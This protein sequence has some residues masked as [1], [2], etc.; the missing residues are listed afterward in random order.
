MKPKSSTTITLKSTTSPTVKANRGTKSPGRASGG[1]SAPKG[2]DPP[3]TK[4]EKSVSKSNSSK[5]KS[6]FS[7]ENSS[8]SETPKISKVN[9]IIHHKPKPELRAKASTRTVGN[10]KNEKTNEEE[11]LIVKENKGMS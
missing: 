8:E 2:K 6:I 5:K 10:V 11:S 7:P 1:K 4:T 9:K 3:K